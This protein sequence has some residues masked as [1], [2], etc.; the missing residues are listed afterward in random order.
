MG[1]LTFPAANP[2][3][4][5]RMQE[6]R[7]DKT[8]PREAFS[9]DL[10]V[11]PRSRITSVS[12]SSAN[13]AMATVFGD[14]TR[15]AVH[16]VTLSNPQPDTAA[17]NESTVIY[18]RRDEES[19]WT[20][21][22]NP[23]LCA[24]ESLFAVG[25]S[26]QVVLYAAGHSRWS[27][28]QALRRLPGD[29]FS[30]DWLSASSLAVGQRGGYITLW[31]TRSDGSALRLRHPSNV[32]GLRCVDANML[33][34]CGIQDALAMY[35]LRMPRVGN[36][37]KSLPASQAVVR[38]AYKNRDVPGRGFDVDARHGLVA[39]VDGQNAIQLYSLQTG[40]SLSLPPFQ[41]AASLWPPAVR[42]PVS[43]LQFTEMGG[44]DVLLA[45]RGGRLV[46]LRW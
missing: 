38:Y 35:D 32:T 23:F 36:P 20:S 8:R 46:A 45:S 29:A 4:A 25:M 18:E 7:H 40:A 15:A 24:S 12:L 1:S 9:A 34:A 3:Y 19:I 28:A 41:T 39:A 26:S 13:I 27:D 11:R 2:V 5:S 16:L 21:S 42:P 44:E 10:M 17:L 14:A 30:I 31:D 37:D 6:S 33:V 22:A 43:C